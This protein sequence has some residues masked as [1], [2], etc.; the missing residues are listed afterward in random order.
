MILTVPLGLGRFQP[1]LIANAD[2]LAQGFDVECGLAEKHLHI[3]ALNVLRLIGRGAQQF[4]DVAFL[5]HA[6]NSSPAA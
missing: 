5:G 6:A 3:G 1:D 2:K 4:N